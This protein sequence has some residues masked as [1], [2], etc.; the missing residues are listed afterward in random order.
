MRRRRRRRIEAL[1]SRF[2][3][4]MHKFGVREHTAFDSPSMAAEVYV[5]IA[6]V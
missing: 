1:D 5:C 4:R 2:R 3:S 6:S